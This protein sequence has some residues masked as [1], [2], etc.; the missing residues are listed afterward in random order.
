MIETIY[1]I[2]KWDDIRRE[3][4]PYRVVEGDLEDAA[5]VLNTLEG[6]FPG[7]EFKIAQYEVQE[8]THVMEI[9]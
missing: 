2:D 4:R 8:I 5:E 1:G 6:F 3:W 7:F 9:E